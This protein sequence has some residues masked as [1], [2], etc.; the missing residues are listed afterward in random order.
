LKGLMN[1]R[2]YI[3]QHLAGFLADESGFVTHFA[4]TVMLLVIIFSGLSLDSSNAWRVKYM[5]Q[6]SADASAHAASMEL[7]NTTNALEAGMALA[8]ANLTV[9]NA[10]AIN[11]ESIEFG[12]WDEDTSTFT[13]TMSNPDA[14][15][16]TAA[17]SEATSNA[18]PTL[19]LRMAGLQS[20]NISVQSVAYRSTEECAVADITTNG[21]FSI[22]SN[23]DFYGSYCAAAAGGIDLSNNNEFDDD[24]RLYVES[25]A[26]LGWPGSVGMN[27]VVGRG[28]VDSSATLTYAN[29]LRE[30]AEISAPYVSDIETLA[31]DYLDP[32]YV[33]Q[34]DYINTS[35]AVI[36]ID[37]RDVKYTSF[38][39]SRIY[40]VV[41]G[42]GAGN[43][44]QFFKNSEVSQVVIVSECRIQLGKGSSFDDVV[45]VSRN[46]GNKSVYAAANVTLGEDDD[47]AAGG[48]VQIFTGG[49][50]SSAAGLHSY[51]LTLSAAGEVS[52]AAQSDGVEGLIIYANGDVSFSAQAS[53]GTCASAEDEDAVVSYL[54]VR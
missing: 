29:I 41:C 14:V 31:D 48:G 22:T 39:P 33:N 37:A 24:N 25:F 20:W 9:G 47:C 49:D 46:T 34:P 35:A 50:F 30:R 45:L 52:M 13:A 18:L 10:S 27:T 32:Y 40:E 7:P 1:M 42:S 44:A 15:R 6:V 36:E 3:R 5:L 8:N 26:D 17:R 28:T 16:V 21:V 51:G 38:I 19:L 11:E 43:K 12:I 54:L 53:F 23:N 2:Q 4:L